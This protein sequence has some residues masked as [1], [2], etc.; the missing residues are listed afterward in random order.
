[1]AAFAPPVAQGLFEDDTRPRPN[2][3]P[4]TVQ[5]LAARIGLTFTPDK[6]AKANTFAPV[7]ILD[8][9]YAV[10]PFSR[11]SIIK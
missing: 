11:L 10:L 1:M 4:A 5:Q 8:Y 7:D 2:L 9:I 6:Q 3:S